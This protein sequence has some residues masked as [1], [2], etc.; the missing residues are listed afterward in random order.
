MN[1]NDA[2]RTLARLIGKGFAWEEDPKALTGDDR[3]AA[4]AEY[5]EARQALEA[6]KAAR[7]A[8]EAELLAA[9]AEFQRL[10]QAVRDADTR[11]GKAS[12]GAHR[13]RLK[14]GTVDRLGRLG[15]VFCIVAAGDNWQEV[16]D[17]V[18]AKK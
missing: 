12:S 1:R 18:K 6:A 2:T 3:E 9:D 5:R 10:R 11:Q 8:R 15:N 13:D 7:D 14:V 17:K 16:V 4:R